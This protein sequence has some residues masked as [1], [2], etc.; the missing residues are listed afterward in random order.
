[1]AGGFVVPDT[2]VTALPPLTFWYCALQKLIGDEG[3]AAIAAVIA[4]GW[5]TALPS[6]GDVTTTDG[7]AGPDV[8]PVGPPGAGIVH[9]IGTAFDAVR[10]PLMK[11][12]A[13]TVSVPELNPAYEKV[14]VP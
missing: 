2:S 4:T 1:V 6:G 10:S 7:G 14:A 8:L 11:A 3:G 5:L 12:V 13:L 9:W